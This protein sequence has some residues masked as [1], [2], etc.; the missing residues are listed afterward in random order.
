[1]SAAI[2]MKNALATLT[3]T[4]L[5]VAASPARADDCLPQ[6]WLVSTR[7]LPQCGDLDGS[8]QG[9]CYWRLTG[10]CEWSPADAT[11]FHAT[12]DAGVPTVV[13]LH[14]NRTRDDE[15]ISKG[16]YVHQVVEAGACGRAFR[17]VIWSWPAEPASHP[18]IEDA[19]LKLY[20]CDAES[21]YLAG[22]LRELKAGLRVSLIGHSYGSQ[23]IANAF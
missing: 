15:A 11:S 1:L 17:Y 20:Y 5:L 6:V 13:Y 12:D 14:G 9:I 23:I 21:Y 18:A 3:L 2:A 19:R 4:I 22:W 10:Q 16:M 7:G 8:S